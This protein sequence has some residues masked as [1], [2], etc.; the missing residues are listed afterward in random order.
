M[1]LDIETRAAC[2][3][4]KCKPLPN[5]LQSQPLPVV[6]LYHSVSILMRLK[7]QKTHF[8]LEIMAAWKLSILA[9]KVMPMSFFRRKKPIIFMEI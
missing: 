5:E 7:R 4:V 2:L 9:L 8:G 6:F 1:V 3:L